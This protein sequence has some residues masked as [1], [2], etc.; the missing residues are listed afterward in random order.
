MTS[1]PGRRS[2]R[3]VAIVASLIGPLVGTARA[4]TVPGDFSTIQ[5]A[6]NAVIGG[7]LPDG[8]TIDVQPGVYYESLLVSSSPRSLTVRGVGGAGAAVIDAAGRGAAVVNVFRTTGRVVFTGLT[9]RNGAPPTA[10]GGGFVVQ[11]ASPSF[12]DCIFEGNTAIDGGGGA[13]ITSNATFTGTTIRNNRAA[14]FGGGVLI[15][16][17][18]RPVFTRC[19]IVNNASGTGGPGVGNIGA[20]G[21]VN[22][23]DSSPTFRGSRIDANTSTFA[24]GGIFHLGVFGSPNGRAMLLVEDSEVADNISSPFSPT[25]NPS[26]GGG[27]HLEDNA[28]ANLIRVRALRNLANTGGGLNAY[29]AEYDIFD[30]VID[31]NQATNGFGGGIAAFSSNVP[32]SPVRPA[33]IINVSQTLVRNNAA[34]T[35]GGIVVAGDTTMGLQATMS[36]T[37]SVVDGNHAPNQGGGILLSMATLSASNSLIT[38]NAGG[39]GGVMMVSASSATITGTAISHNTAGQFGG[40]IFFDAGSSLNLSA[41]QVYDNTAGSRGGGVFVGLNGN[42]SGAIQNSTIADNGPD[43]IREESCTSS[44]TY[45]NNTITPKTGS[46]IYS[47]GPNNP[48]GN[49]S[50]FNASLS[51][52]ASGNNSNVPRF[53]QF[54]AAPSVGTPATLA[55]SVARATTVTIAGVGS[56]SQSTGTTDVAPGSSTTFSLTASTASGGIGPLTATVVVARPWGA[57]MAGDIP[58]PADYDGDGKVDLAVYRSTTGQWFISRSSD[59]GLTQVSW[60][61]PSLGDVPVAADYDGDGKADIAVYRASTGQWFIL[62]SSSSTLMQANWGAPSLGDVPVPADYDG[63]HKAD[64]AVYRASTGQWFILRSS[65]STLMQVNWGAP[66]LG[67]VPVPADYDG[68]GKKDV[69]VFR[70][71]TGQWFVLRSSNGTLLQANWGAPSLGDEPVPADYDGDGK[72]DFAVARP[73]TGEWFVNRST[74]G[75]LLVNWGFGDARVPADYNGNGS[76][77][78]TIWNAASGGWLSR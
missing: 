19:D 6:I 32:G 47:C 55:W 43:Q 7:S 75:F 17:G 22:S 77:E 28:T 56:F 3:A 1:L 21:G 11:Q 67:D 2:I 35:G 14:R 8:T 63:D 78:V 24:A 64:I 57:G 52:R 68:D 40:G 62:R 37:N 65:N 36:L 60:G 66:S 26:E 58:V 30:S 42:P 41:S 10:A 59:G 69:A 9:F 71:T 20:G 4:V 18:S 53:A 23:N 33:S 73:V 39:A 38:R 46:T 12:V 16:S 54:L 31:S 70:S 29:R 72:A 34:T 61:A 27:I 25:D 5:G 51:P 49:I 45:S 74:A 13:L 76:S 44:V 50:Q 15:V 48:I